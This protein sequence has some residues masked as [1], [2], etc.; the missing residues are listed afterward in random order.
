[1]HSDPEQPYSVVQ[2]V[3]K[4][5][6]RWQTT[7][8]SYRDGI[9]RGLMTGALNER[10]RDLSRQPDPPFLGGGTGRG[11]WSP[12]TT[13]EVGYVQ[14]ADGGAERGLEA[15][16]VE[17]ERARRH[18]FSEAE[19]ERARARALSRRERSWR[20]RDT[21]QS[22]HVI[23]ELIRNFI[24]DETVPGSDAEWELAQRYLPSITLDEVNALTA[25]WLDG[26][27]R[28]VTAVLPARE[29]ASPPTEE[30][31][32]SVLAAVGSQ[33]IPPLVSEV[34]EGPLVAEPPEPGSVVSRREIPELEVSE[35]TLSNGVVVLI[36]QTDFKADE[37][38]FQGWIDGGHS[39][40]SD[41]D[42][43]A[44]VT[45]TSVARESGVG[46]F[47]A[48][49]LT[50]YLAGKTLSARPFVGVTR[51]GLSGSSSPDDLELALEL[52]HAWATDA[53]FT[54]DGF[55]TVQTRRLETAANRELRPD[56]AL[57]DEFSRLLWG[58]HPRS[59]PWTTG[60]VEEMDRARSEAFFRARFADFRDATFLFLGN[61]DP[62]ALEPMLCRWV[63][64]LPAGEGGAAFVDV[65]KV[66]AEGI[67]EAVVHKGIDPKAR[68]KM[69]ISG[70]FESTPQTRHDLKMLGRLLSMRL[71]EE[72]RE[73]LGGVYSVGG[74]ISTD[75][76]PQQRYAIKI[77][78]GCDPE[79]V[80]ELTAAAFGVLNE[81]RDGPLEASYAER[82]A[83]TQRRAIET[84]MRK[85][86]FWSKA[87]R[88][89]RERG[90][91]PSAIPLYWGLHETVTAE[92]LHTTARTYID[93]ERYVK[94]VLLPAS[95]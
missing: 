62:E 71:R 6:E 68:V 10:L 84:G 7:H 39:L 20:E 49:Q 85:N 19:V 32:A 27:S 69:R 16:M 61:V 76:D 92:S 15:V 67:H 14:V 75:Y 43:P 41:A 82:I 55:A 94:V 72:L 51:H 90:E 26:P 18:G 65:G 33:D 12:T 89:N 23:Q 1:M 77:D 93:L 25:G 9:V 37:V 88:G 66:P 87:I 3:A 50:K 52:L 80:D 59:L 74:S 38:R 22:N 56:T 53:R 44:A 91:D 4:R 81:L 70:T 78:F 60:R 83:E 34:V 58:G 13:V 42:Y 86:R 11:R 79:R 64:T 95:E 46:P 48:S 35:W 40:A 63:A 5:A 36:K 47:D 30:S 54:D 17:V 8:R 2:I 28:V 45:A 57:T 24:D 31:L 29:G 73:E 21:Q